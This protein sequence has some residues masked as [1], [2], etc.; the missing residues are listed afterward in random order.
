M[1]KLAPPRKSSSIIYTVG[2]FYG[3]V[4]FILD[5]LVHNFVV[6]VKLKGYFGYKIIQYNINRGKSL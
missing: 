3:M 2:F 5:N 1:K 6:V 4:A